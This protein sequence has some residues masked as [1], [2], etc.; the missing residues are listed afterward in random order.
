MEV[1][2]EI[3]DR[4]TVHYTATQ[5]NWLNQAEIGIG[6]FSRQCLGSRRIPDLQML[7]RESRA[8]N[9]PE[10]EPNQDQLDVRPSRPCLMA[11]R[12]FRAA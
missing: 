9:R 10:P 6:L 3:W 8:W 4:F 5:G 11:R 12:L 1:G 2:T 7:R